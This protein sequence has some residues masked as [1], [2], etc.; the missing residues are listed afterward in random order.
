[1]SVCLS[2]IIFGSRPPKQAKQRQ[3]AVRFL[4]LAFFCCTCDPDG[5]DYALAKIIH[6]E[7]AS[8]SKQGAVIT[9]RVLIHLLLLS[10]A[11]AFV[12]PFAQQAFVPPTTT[13]TTTTTTSLQSSTTPQKTEVEEL[14][15]EIEEMKAEALRRMKALES[16]LSQENMK[17]EAVAPQEEVKAAVSVEKEVAPRVAVSNAPRKTETLVT[18]VPIQPKDD[19]SL[20]DGTRWKVML[21]IGREPGTYSVMV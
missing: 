7:G 9:M 21:N 18:N 12:L 20:L 2:K 13:T 16:Q 6:Q 11:S 15:H 8:S 17:T 5:I 4:L 14:K 1:L 3:P 19:M 10:C